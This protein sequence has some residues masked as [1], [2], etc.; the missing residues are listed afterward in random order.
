MSERQ[1]MKQ[2]GY[3]RIYDIGKLRY[4]WYNNVDGL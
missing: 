4:V 1:I 3:D 2:V